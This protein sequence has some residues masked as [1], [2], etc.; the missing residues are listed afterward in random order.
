MVLSGSP[1][2]RGVTLIELL[3]TLAVLGALMGVLLPALWSARGGARRSEC[4]SNLRQM[5]VAAQQHAATRD[6]WPAAIRYE[7][8]DGVMLASA[9]DWV[10]GAFGGEVVGPGALWSFTDH[11]ERV[12]QC[13]EYHG[14]TNFADPFTGYN[15][16]TSHVGDEERLTFDGNGCVRPG[17][18]P[19]ACRRT[20]P[21]AIFGD[22]G[23]G[24]GAT[25]KFM[26][27]PLGRSGTDV[28]TVGGEPALVYAGGQA[29]RHQGS[30][31]AAFLDG[32]V[33]CGDQPAP[34]AGADASLI[35]VLGF[36]RNGFLSND[37]SAYDPR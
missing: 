1:R 26:R 28:C 32:H 16:N 19:G 34:G 23:R 21:C 3:V 22:G 11:P 9:W 37:D 14:S 24:V 15:Y 8:R 10:T 31:C 13:P 35:G 20:A 5:G 2:R 12:M 6:A 17:V 25:N 4:L 36:P 7:L 30:T 18:R 33:D 27:A 29:F